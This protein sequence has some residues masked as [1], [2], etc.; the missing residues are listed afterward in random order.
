MSVVHGIMKASDGA[1]AVYSEP[2]NGT[3][4]HLFF[5]AFEG[6]EE[7]PQPPLPAP[8]LGHRERVLFVDDEPV[9]TALGERFLARLGYHP[10]TTNDP[11]QAIAMY[12]AQPFDL[13]ITDLQMPRCNGLE[14]GRQL[15]EWHPSVPMILT[16]G[17]SAT[18]T[19][20]R[21]REHGFRDLLIKPY[22]IH[23]LGEVVQQ[24]LVRPS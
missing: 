7:T 5:P 9:L 15:L 22:T 3:V 8:P 6:E 14:L 20:E 18:V 23:T 4:A 13:V 12:R 24:A 21:A 1:I 10:L 19:V 16:T 17:Y 11:L 2:G